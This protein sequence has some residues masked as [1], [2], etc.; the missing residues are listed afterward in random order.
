MLALVDA[1][2]L[3]DITESISVCRDAKDNMILELAISGRADVI[4]TEDS[5]LLVLNPFQG[6]AVLV[7]QMFL[8]KYSS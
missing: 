1:G 8:T 4:V 5:D 3:V 2:V 6:M 7:P